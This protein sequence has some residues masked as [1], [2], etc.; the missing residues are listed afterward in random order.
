MTKAEKS[1]VLYDVANSA[2]VLVIVTAIMPIYFK[3]VVAHNIPGQLATAW[4][5]YAN[6][7]SAMAMVVLAPVM[8]TFADYSGWK[9]RLLLICLLVGLAA[10]VLL[11]QT[12]EGKII[13]CLAVF[14]VARTAWEGT[15]LF[16]DAF[17]PDVAELKRMDRVSASGFAWGYVGSV[18]PF[19]A[20]IALILTGKDQAGGRIPPDA[21][22]TG[23]LI[24]AAWWGLFSIPLLR[25]V[26]QKHGYPREPGAFRL[27]M[28]RLTDTFR[29]VSRHR[30]AFLFLLAYFFYIDG[31]GTVITMAVA[32]GVDVGLKPDMLILVILVIQIV[33]FPA[34]LVWGKLSDRFRVKPL[35]FSGI[36][37]YC[38]ITLIAFMI[39]AIPDPTLKKATFWVIAVLVAS[40]MGG[41]QA[42][43]RSFYGKLIPPEKSGEFFGFYN[44]FGKFAA[45]GGPFLMGITAQMTGSSRY[46][47]LSILLLFIAGSVILGRVDESCAGS[48][49]PEK[50]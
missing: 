9:K 39:P 27:S 22:R 12:G 2:F 38:I 23:F 35:L 10:T 15:N 32:Y 31:V 16:Y 41:I 14:V 11:T 28:R 34:A 33:A 36:A 8:G 48:G 40:A 13:L 50:A 21:A 18:I 49:T 47:V 6:S 1:W 43:S 44:I 45:M 20:V 4:W 5:G 37:V 3:E 30:N 19:L 42:L 26:S 46:G 17:L 25:N 29:D 24:V 7:I